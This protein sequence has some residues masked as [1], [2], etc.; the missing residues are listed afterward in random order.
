VPSAV[1]FGLET[2]HPLFLSVENKWSETVEGN[3]F[4]EDEVI[5]PQ[6]PNIL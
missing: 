4:A 5:N 6:Y 2:A 1:I 3:P